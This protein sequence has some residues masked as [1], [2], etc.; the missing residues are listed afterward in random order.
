VK[1]ALIILS[2]VIVLVATGIFLSSPKSPSDTRS[3]A[4]SEEVGK[5]RHKG[6]NDD[7][8]NPHDPDAK[9]AKMKD[10]STH[11]AHKAEHAVD[12]DS[13]AVLAVTLQGANAQGTGCA[14]KTAHFCHFHGYPC[15][16]WMGKPLEMFWQLVFIC[17]RRLPLSSICRLRIDRMRRSSTGW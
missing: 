6:S 2:A 10:G 16:G 9:I 12:M 8:K 4:S 3:I 13:G 5:R 15:M 14:A 11:M 7:W 17:E 1:K